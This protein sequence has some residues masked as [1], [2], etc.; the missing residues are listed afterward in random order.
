MSK[1]ESMAEQLA[2]F[3]EQLMDQ[4]KKNKQLERE[5]DWLAKRAVTNGRVCVL[6]KLTD[7]VCSGKFPHEVT[8]EDCVDCWRREA[9]GAVSNES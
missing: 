8:S 2:Y 6:P 4:V 3:S 9:R 1:Y 5:A 7:R